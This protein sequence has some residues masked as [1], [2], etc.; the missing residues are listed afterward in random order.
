MTQNAELPVAVIGAGPVG[1]AAAARLIERGIE[2]LVFEKGASA[3]AAVLEWGHVRVFSPW[4]YNIDD[5]ARVLLEDAGWSKPDPDYH[6]NGKEIVD[7]YLA[8]LSKVPRIAQGLKLGATVTAI[9]RKGLSK[10]GSKNRDAAPFVVRYEQDGIEKNVLAVIDASGTWGQPNPLGVDG[11]IIPGEGSFSYL[12]YGIPDVVGARRSEFAGKR[13]LVVGSGHS[14]IN[15]AIALM[16]LQDADPATEIFWALRHDGVDCLLGGGLNDKLPE[17]GALGLAA[18]QAMEDGRLN[19]LTSFSADSIMTDGG[20]TVLAQAGGERIQLSIDQIVVT[21]GFRPDFGF[22]RELRVEVDPVVEAPPALA[23]LIDPNLHSCG[24]VPPH[25]VE[26]LSHPEKDFYIVGMKS[27]GRAPTFLMK[28]GYE[29]VRSVVA[30]IAG[31]HVAARRVE[32]VLPETGV[33]SV[34]TTS[35]TTEAGCCGGPAPADVDACCVADA[36]AKDEGKSGCGCGSKAAPEK[37]AESV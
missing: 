10:V 14:A 9:T 33:C 30:E 28:T 2:P 26:E 8:P 18:K 17:R 23:P 4:K 19:M 16:E 3:G 22:L 13:T 34:T 5:A 37:V 24:T 36:V 11:L 29:Q 1:L 20:P 35:N 21:T 32:L 7:G 6:P 25:G 31:D 15:V 12:S 27:Y